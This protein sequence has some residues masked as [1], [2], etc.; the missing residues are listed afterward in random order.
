MQSIANQS[1]GEEVLTGELKGLNIEAME[2]PSQATA[3]CELSEK[4]FDFAKV[5][6]VPCGANLAREQT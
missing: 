4:G 5:T 2:L 1:L 6:H 3:T